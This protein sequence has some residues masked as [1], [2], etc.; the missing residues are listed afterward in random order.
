MKSKG[1]FM[2]FGVFVFFIDISLYGFANEGFALLL[3]PV[4]NIFHE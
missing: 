3:T 4:N 2:K 1:G